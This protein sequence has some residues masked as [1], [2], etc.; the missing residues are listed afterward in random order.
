MLKIKLVLF[1]VLLQQWTLALSTNDSICVD[2]YLDFEEQTFDNNSENRVT[3]FQAFYPP[4]DHLPYSVVVTYQA[5]LPNG[6]KVNIS[7]DPSCPD[8][9]VWQSVSSPFLLVMNPTELNRLVPYTLNHFTEWVP[10]HLTIATPLPCSAEAEGFLKLMTTS[11]STCSS[12]VASSHVYI[13]F[14]VCSM[15][16][17]MCCSSSPQLQAYALAEMSKGYSCQGCDTTNMAIISVKDESSAVSMYHIIATCGLVALF[18]WLFSN[19]W[20]LFYCFKYSLRLF[21]RKWNLATT[22]LIIMV[23]S[24][25]CRPFPACSS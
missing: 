9:Q 4:N 12:T 13:K 14:L 22:H 18:P 8:R 6:T 7:T 11:V 16:L 25:E 10:P 15:L 19:Q 1:L 20:H 17:F 24:G 5:A 2:N 23:C 3:L 21:H